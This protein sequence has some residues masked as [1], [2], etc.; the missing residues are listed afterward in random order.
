METTLDFLPELRKIK[1]FL[2][3][4]Q[5]LHGGLGF[6]YEHFEAGAVLVSR[7]ITDHEERR[8]L[9]P[10][11]GYAIMGAKVPHAWNYHKESGMYYD[12]AFD[13]F[14]QS[15]V[16][17]ILP[18]KVGEGM[19]RIDTEGKLVESVQKYLRAH[20]KQIN[21]LEEMYRTKGQRSFKIA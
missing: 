2:H 16:S 1:K 15:A 20:E 19:Y 21:A 13:R 10:I 12:I 5:V 8:I 3:T 18:T 4:Q 14:G 11:F 7:L 6:P 9:E 17:D